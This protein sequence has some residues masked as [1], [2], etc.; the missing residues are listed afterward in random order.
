MNCY[1]FI[2]VGGISMSALALELKRAGYS[3]QGSDLKPT[4]IT[5]KL[6]SAGIKVFYGHRASNVNE[7]QF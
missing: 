5:R 6:E 1:H 4:E 3:V 7:N 2:G